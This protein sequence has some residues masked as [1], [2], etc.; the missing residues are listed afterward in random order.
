MHRAGVAMN[1]P[2]RRD[3]DAMDGPPTAVPPPDPCAA[4]VNR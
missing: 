1:H 2:T 4:T 3:L